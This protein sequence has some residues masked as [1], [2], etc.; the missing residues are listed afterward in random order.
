MIARAPTILALA[1]LLAGET[2]AWAAD[3]APEILH[4]QAQFKEICATC[5]T[6]EPNK[7]KIGPTLFGLIGRRS[8]SVPGFS[9][10]EAMR[11]AGIV[12]DVASLDKYLADPKG[13]V[14]GNK[15]PYLGVKKPEA[16]REI[17]SYLS[18]LR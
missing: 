5:H 10:S 9:Y 1:V 7:N 8:G 12:W 13:V 15:M 2:A 4:G 16:R 11:N 14:P 3:D 6:S 17:I 18:T